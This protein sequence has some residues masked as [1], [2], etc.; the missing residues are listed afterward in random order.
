MINISY[1][2]LVHNEAMDFKSN[3]SFIK[4]YLERGDEIV[5]VADNPT[6]EVITIL[7]YF[8]DIIGDRFKVY[9]R[10]LNGNFG[11]QKNYLNSVCSGTYIFN[12]DADEIPSTTLI[13]SLKDL[14][15]QNSRADVISVPRIN[16][17]YGIT[18][19]HLDKWGW[20]LS[21]LKVEKLVSA[22]VFELSSPEFKLLQMNDLVKSIDKFEDNLYMVTYYDPIIQFPDY[23]M[24]IYKNKKEIYWKNK[25]H[26]VLVGYKTISRIP[27]DI[28]KDLFLYHIKNITKQEQ[29][30]NFYQTL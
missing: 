29:Q 5:V 13:N 11:E 8:S 6:S 4:E 22:N 23:Q 3:V 28:N 21:S 15:D 10:N 7:N 24:R 20:K 18:Q 26:E 19:S 2:F 9:H 25:V 1:A 16:I 30:N 12:I 14:L 17:V 27:G